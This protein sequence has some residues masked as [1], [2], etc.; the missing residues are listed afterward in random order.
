MRSLITLVNLMG[1]N[2]T[3][4]SHPGS[5]IDLK[6]N[7]AKSLRL[8]SLEKACARQLPVGLSIGAPLTAIVQARIRDQM[9]GAGSI[10]FMVMASPCLALLSSVTVF[11]LSFFHRTATYVPYTPQ[12]PIKKEQTCGVHD[13]P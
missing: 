13:K 11:L 5:P 4:I 7:K 12:E 9:L 3:K 10:S 1:R 6:K 2:N 8:A